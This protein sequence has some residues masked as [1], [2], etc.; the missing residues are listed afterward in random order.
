MKAIRN[1]FC[2][3]VCY[4]LTSCALNKMVCVND[5]EKFIIEIGKKWIAS[6]GTI[7]ISYRVYNYISDL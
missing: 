2:V 1:A 5:D 4:Y 7:Y 3:G 6:L